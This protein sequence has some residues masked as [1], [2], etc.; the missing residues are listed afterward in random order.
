MSEPRN[1]TPDGGPTPA[2]PAHGQSDWWSGSWDSRRRGF[3]LLGVLLVL[4]GVG[5]LL[6]Y[7]YPTVGI[8]TLILL[9]IGLAFLAAWLV[10]R[11]WLSMV[12]GVLLVALGVAQL[13]EDLAVFRPAHQDVPGLAAT[14]LA[15][16]FVI[17]WAIAGLAGRR[18]QWP[19]WA[20]AIFAVIGVAQ[21]STFVTVP[22][23]GAIVPV[24][25]IVLGLIMLFEW[26]RERT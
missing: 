13:L 20:A 9:A 1:V 2:T 6:Q 26:R 14:S 8:G 19:L 12:P 23:L 17:I 7:M 18:W 25:I 3:P 11:S 5:L 15:I 24:L 10:G 4:V 22:E 16:G 21:L